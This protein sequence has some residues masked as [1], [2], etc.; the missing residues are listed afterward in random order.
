MTQTERVLEYMRD[1]GSISP[2]DAIRD[3]GIYRFSAR[4]F[5]LKEQGHRVNTTI[6]SSK[7]RYGETIH[8]AVYTLEVPH[9]PT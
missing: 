7:N 4:I 5:D 8:Y 2:L 1:F 3:L 6:T 9:D